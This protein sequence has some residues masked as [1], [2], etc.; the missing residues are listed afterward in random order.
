MTAPTIYHFHGLTGEYL[1]QGTAD[2][3]PM[4]EGEWLFP[5]NCTAIAPPVAASGEV[6]VWSSSDWNMFADHRGEIWWNEH[7]LTISVDFIGEPSDQGLS[8]TPPD[9]QDG[10]REALR[11]DF[12]GALL[13]LGH[14]TAVQTAVS[15]AGGL[16]EIMWDDATSFMENDPTVA[17]MAAQLSID[18]AAV[19][20]E[21]ENV[22]AARASSLVA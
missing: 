11:A 20:D 17:A 13:N 21:A 1:G 7:G 3:D 18:V 14:L 2:P 16:V 12:R 15:A 22:K 6:A 10:P 19:F 9:L 5:A 4:T 8:P